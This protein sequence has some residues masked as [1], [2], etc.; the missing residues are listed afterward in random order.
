[1]QHSD[2]ARLG[3]LNQRMYT[4][5]EVA[6]IL[7][8][9]ISTLRRWR[10]GCPAQGP[11]FVRISERVAKYPERDLEAYLEARHITPAA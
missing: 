3:L 5:A 2:H 8:V 7:G 11:G 10:R 4:T 9:D 1:M 6:E